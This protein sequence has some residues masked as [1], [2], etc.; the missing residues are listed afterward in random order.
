MQY[1]LSSLTLWG[2]RRRSFTNAFLARPKDILRVLGDGPHSGFTSHSWS[3]S[4][5]MATPFIERFTK[6]CQGAIACQILSFLS[7]FVSPSLKMRQRPRRLPGPFREKPF[8]FRKRGEPFPNKW[9][10]FILRCANRGFTLF[11]RCGTFAVRPVCSSVADSIR[12]L[13]VSKL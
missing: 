2:S 9:T 4:F 12:R 10:T 5:L 7:S 3:S 8:S 1:G 6:Q 11:D 13:P